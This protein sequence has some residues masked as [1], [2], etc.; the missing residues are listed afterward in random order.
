MI[1]QDCGDTIAECRCDHIAIPHCKEH[2]HPICI[3]GELYSM[4]HRITTHSEVWY[5]RIHNGKM[6]WGSNKHEVLMN[7]VNELSAV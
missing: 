4:V 6:I 1:C 3:G 7:A 2:H 5:I